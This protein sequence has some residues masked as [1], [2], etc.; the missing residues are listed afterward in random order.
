MTREELYL[1]QSSWRQVLPIAPQAAEL[2]YFRLFEVAPELTALF[3]GDMREQGQRLMSMI[4]AAVNEMDRWDELVPTL[5]ALG[6]RHAGYGVKPADYDAVASALLWT[7][8]KGLGEA[9][10]EEVKQAWAKTYGH[11]ADTMKGAAAETTA[12]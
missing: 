2:F 4:D 11:M 8:E 6:E 5:R 7:L 10:T 12:A 3:K 1:V 9:F